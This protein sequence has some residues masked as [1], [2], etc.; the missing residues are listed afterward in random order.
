MPP[1]HP[2]FEFFR[3]FAPEPPGEGAPGPQSRGVGSGFIISADG[4][5]LTNAHV[6]AGRGVVTVRLADAKRQFRGR[7]IGTDART[8]VAL[9]KVEA[10]GLPVARIGNSASLQAGEWVAA[11]GSPFGLANTITGGIEALLA[12]QR[13]DEP[14]ALFVR[15]GANSLYVARSQRRRS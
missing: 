13:P 15:R 2:L 11:I 4:Y 12:L 5:I 1:D 6:V 14:M 7:V 8:D 3:R 10:A 9:L